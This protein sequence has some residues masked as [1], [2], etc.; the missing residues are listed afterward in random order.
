MAAPAIVSCAQDAWTKIATGVTACKIW[1]IIGT[2][3]YSLS[4]RATTDPA[5]TGL[6]EAGAILFQDKNYYD[7]TS[8]AS[9]DVY[10]YCR[11]DAG[12]VRV[13]T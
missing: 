3:L 10:I 5:P 13:D 9:A 8:G 1:K 7:F 12:S 11:G 4:Y 6:T 2:A